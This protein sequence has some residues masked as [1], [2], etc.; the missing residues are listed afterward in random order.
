MI[1]TALI[2][3]HGQPSEPEP[4]ENALAAL[5]L[6][7]A[8]HLPGWRVL[9]ATLA[10]PGAL[11]AALEGQAPGLVYPMFMAGGWFPLVEL[12]RRVEQAGGADWAFLPPFGIDPGVQALGLTLVQEAAVK[13]GRL[14]RETPVLLAAH[15]SFRSAAP[16]EVAKGFAWALARA[17]FARAEAYFIDQDPKISTARGF[18][19]EAICLPFFAA[20]GGHVV[21]DLPA[22]LGEAG[23]AG[24]VLPPLGLDT[25]VPG[26]IARA[27]R[28]GAVG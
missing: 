11:A 24:T 6:D 21:D 13:L 2:V 8:V 17:G 28:A 18:G 16:A 5:A 22:A 10:N 7:V 26:L 23:F 12:P 15:G 27:L 9:S 14:P 25:R 3:G 20:E 4:A 19:A 1:Q